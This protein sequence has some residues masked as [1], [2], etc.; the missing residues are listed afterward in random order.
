MRVSPS[1]W[2]LDRAARLVHAE[3]SIREPQ[4]SAADQREQDQ[5]QLQRAALVAG[6]AGR[7]RTVNF[8]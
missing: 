1:S 7:D 5:E 6:G 4:H 8:Q 3:L 2:Q